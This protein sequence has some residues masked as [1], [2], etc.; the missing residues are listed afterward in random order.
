MAPTP[1]ANYRTIRGELEHYSPA[2]AARPELVVVTKM[3]L[4]G[5]TEARD[6]IQSELNVDMLA[7]S[8]VSGLGV[9]ALIARNQRA[10]P[11]LAC[12]VGADGARPVNSPRHSP[13]RPR[14]RRTPDVRR[15]VA[16]LG[17]SRIKWAESTASGLVGHVAV[18]IDDADAWTAALREISAAD[19]AVSS[20]NPPLSSRF[21]EILDESSAGSLRWFRAASEI[22]IRYEVEGAETGGADRALAVLA[23]SA[24]RPAGR[25]FRVVLCGTAIT[26]ERASAEGVWQGGSIAPGSANVGPGAPP[27]HGGPSPDRPRRPAARLGPRDRPLGPCRRRLGGP[28]AWSAS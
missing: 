5:S 25:A 28:S 19:W 9:P 11:R 10:T 23:A 24:I 18:P 27:L 15:F 17:N 12:G 13:C 16:D 22:P 6:R 2:L 1:L 3:D 4:T 8:A 21:G 14:S 7:I 26:V 20:V